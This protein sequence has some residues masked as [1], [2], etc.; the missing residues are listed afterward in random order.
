MEDAIVKM[1]RIDHHIFITCRGLEGHSRLIW[2][3]KC[4]NSLFPEEHKS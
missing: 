4:M 1:C 2:V 3:L